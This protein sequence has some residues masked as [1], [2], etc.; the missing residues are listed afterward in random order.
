MADARIE[1]ASRAAS[2]FAELIA[3]GKID[4]PGLYAPDA[5]GW[6]NTDEVWAP[7][8]TAPE[9][10]AAVRKFVPDFH[11]QEIVTH[12]WA[13]GF[14]VQYAFVGTSVDGAEIRIPGCIV[15]VLGDDGLIQR[16]QEYVDS[17]HA[18][19]LTKALETAT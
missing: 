17:A 19:P 9:R 14:A 10:M 5:T 1:Q 13:G 8:A 3:A 18:A 15:A 6:H 11:A 2:R 12:P 4:A 7:M 16:V